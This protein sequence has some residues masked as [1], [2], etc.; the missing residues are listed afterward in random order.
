MYINLNKL[1]DFFV[2][3]ND[4]QDNLISTDT[5]KPLSANQ[6][7][8]LQDSKQ[9]TLISGT[10]IKTINDES[11]LGSGNLTISSGSSIIGG[12]VSRITGNIEI[13]DN[14]TDTIEITLTDLTT[15]GVS[16]GVSYIFWVEPLYI[17]DVET[18]ETVVEE[19]DITIVTDSDSLPIECSFL[20]SLENYQNQAFVYNSE[21]VAGGMT[22]S[23]IY[24][25]YFYNLPD[26]NGMPI[27]TTL[28]NLPS[29][30]QGE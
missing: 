23:D 18:Q 24:T 29:N 27:V 1:K 8:V 22:F 28:S 14:E 7:K 30:P 26:S 21:G 4:I 3:R 10:N 13:I 2:C 5:N 11:I 19:E 17:I 15:R 12:Y 20:T 6:G 9:N 16:G 25:N